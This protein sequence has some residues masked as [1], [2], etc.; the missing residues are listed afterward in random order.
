MQLFGI[1]FFALI[2]PI[3]AVLA[4]RGRRRVMLWVTVSIG[5]FGLV[6]APMFVAG[7]VGAVAMM[8]SGSFLDGPHLR[9]A[10]HGDFRTVS[11]RRCATRA[12]RWPSASPASWALRWR[13]TSPPGWPR[14]YGLQYVGYYLSA[15]A[16]LTLAGAAFDPGDERRR[17]CCGEEVTAGMDNSFSHYNQDG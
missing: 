6:M 11:R 17:S 2:I 4:E 15:S 5:I 7:T 3:S 16:V 10:R 1:C 14:R 9:T 13:R 8:A 12:A